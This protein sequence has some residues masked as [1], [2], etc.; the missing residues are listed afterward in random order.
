MGAWKVGGTADFL[1]QRDGNGGRLA[2]MK[3]LRSRV[4]GEDRGL[5]SGVSG[6]FSLWK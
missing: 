1:W 2:W 6:A 4:M 5:V 3:W